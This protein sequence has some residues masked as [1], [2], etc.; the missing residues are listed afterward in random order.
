MAYLTLTGPDD[1]VACTSPSTLQPC[2]LT[3]GRLSKSMVPFWTP[4]HSNTASDM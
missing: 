1:F 4:I 2:G 3:F